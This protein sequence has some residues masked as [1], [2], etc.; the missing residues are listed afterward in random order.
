V[1]GTEDQP[2][3]YASFMRSLYEQAKVKAINK[4]LRDQSAQNFIDNLINN[5]DEVMMQ[6]ATNDALVS[7]FQNETVLGKIGSSITNAVPFSPLVLPF[8]RTPSAVAM[9]IVNYTPVGAV[10]EVIRQIGKKEFNQ[11]DFSKAVGRSVFGIG[12]M[13]IG[14]ALFKAGMMALDWPSDEKERELWRLEGR[15]PNTILINGKWRSPMVL[16]PAGNLLIIGGHFQNAFENSGSPT[17]AMAVATTGS[18]KSFTE[19]TF[20][21]GANRAMQAVTDP[22]RSAGNFVGGI[23]SGVVPTIVSDIA[24]ATDPLER[25]TD[26]IL[27]RMTALAG[28]T[29]T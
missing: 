5:P 2:F 22:E 9:Q 24:R 20:L 23:A 21:T 4:G 11:R 26:S 14:I 13:A 29:G 16:G 15:K 17:E 18:L 10:N 7:V 27:D 12:V 19:Q 3:Y 8:T 25:R 6:N 1:L 28:L